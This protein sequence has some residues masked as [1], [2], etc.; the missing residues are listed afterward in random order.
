MNSNQKNTESQTKN[1]KSKIQNYIKQQ[2][3][4]SKKKDMT[5]EKILTQM[6]IDSFIGE[7]EQKFQTTTFDVIKESLW[8][9]QISKQML[10]KIINKNDKILAIISSIL[11]ILDG[12]FNIKSNKINLIYLRVPYVLIYQSFFLLQSTENFSILFEVGLHKSI[13]DSKQQFICFDIIQKITLIDIFF[14]QKGSEITDTILD[15][16]RNNFQDFYRSDLN[17]IECISL[18]LTGIN[19][20]SQN[21]LF[22][23]EKQLWPESIY[24]SQRLKFIQWIPLQFKQLMEQ[25]QNMLF[26]GQYMKKSFHEKLNIQFYYEDIGN[27]NKYKLIQFADFES[28]GQILDLLQKSQ[29]FKIKLSNQE[30]QI[31]GTKNNALVIG[32]SGTGKTT[33]IVLRIFATEMLVKVRSKLLGQK[34]IQFLQDY[35]NK[36]IQIHSIFST[37]NK[38]LVQEVEKYYHK[39]ERQAS[40]AIIKHRQTQTFNLDESFVSINESVI[41]NYEYDV[42]DFILQED[43][44]QNSQQENIS[45]LENSKSN[46]KSFQQINF[47]GFLSVEQILIFLDKQSQN[48]FFS[49][50]RINKFR[51][52]HR[53][54]IGFL[55]HNGINL[56]EWFPQSN[57]YQQT[58][59]Q[60]ST[61]QS[62]KN[63]KEIII[64]EVDFMLFYLQFWPQEAR[65]VRHNFY[66]IALPSLIWTQIYSYI[67]GSQYSYMYP[68]RYLPFQLYKERVENYLTEAQIQEIYQCFE[69]YEK[70]K[71]EQKLFDQLD[72]INSLLKNIEQNQLI[73]FPIHYSYVD[74]VQDLPQAMI[75]LFCKIT[76]QG[77]IFCGDT[78]Q[79]ILKGIGFRFSDLQTIFKTS[80]QIGSNQIEKFQVYQL[81]TNF[82]SHNSIL[83][84]ANCI[85]I[86]LELLFPNSLDHLQ[87]EIS[88]LKGP[89]PI[90]ISNNK[91]ELINDY[92]NLDCDAEEQCDVE[93]GFNQ[94]IIVK[95]QEAKEALPKQFKTARVLTT[96]QAKGLEFD[97]VII[98]NCFST[99]PIPQEQWSLL[100]CIDVDQ[101]YIDKQVFEESITKY[102]EQNNTNDWELTKDAQYVIQKKLKL[103]QRYDKTKVN[104]YSSL[105]NE[106]KMLYV[107]ITRA[108]KR[109]IIYDDEPAQRSHLERILKKYNVCDFIEE[110]SQ[111]LQLAQNRQ[112]ELRQKQLFIQKTEEQQ[113]EFQEGQQK[114]KRRI[115]NEQQKQ[116]WEQQGQL[117]FQKKLYDEAEKCF[118]ICQNQKMEYLSS[119]FNIATKGS[120]KLANYKSYKIKFQTAATL[121][122][123]KKIEQL[124]QQLRQDF[125][126]AAFKF[127]DPLINDQFQ[128]A[129]CFYSGMM[130]EDSTILFLNLKLYPQAAKSAKKL[131]QILLAIIIY[132][133]IGRLT[134][135]LKLLSN[136]YQDE[137]FKYEVL[138]LCFSR[139]LLDKDEIKQYLLKQMKEKYNIFY[140]LVE[141]SKNI[142]N[143]IINKEKFILENFSKNILAKVAVKDLFDQELNAI[144]DSQ[145]YIKDDLEEMM[146][147]QLKVFWN[148]YF[149]IIDQNMIMNNHNKEN[150]SKIFEEKQIK[151]DEILQEFAIEVLQQ[152]NQYQ[153]LIVLYPQKLSLLYKYFPSLNFKT[154][155]IKEQYYPKI[156]DNQISLLELFFLGQFEVLKETLKYQNEDQKLQFQEFFDLLLEK[157]QILEIKNQNLFLIKSYYLLGY[158]SQV[159]KK[160]KPMIFSQ[161]MEEM[162]NKQFSSRFSL[163]FQFHFSIQQNK[164]LNY[165]DMDKLLNLQNQ[166]EK[167]MI[168]LHFLYYENEKFQN[169]FIQSCNF[170]Q[171]L[172]LKRLL[173]MVNN[174]FNL[175]YEDYQN[176]ENIFSAI[177]SLNGKYVSESKFLNVFGQSMLI[178]LQIN[179]NEFYSDQDIYQKNIE[180]IK[181]IQDSVNQ[182][183]EVIFQFLFEEMIQKNSYQ[184][185][186]NYQFLLENE[187][188]IPYIIT[189]IDQLCYDINNDKIPK[190]NH[191]KCLI[192]AI[193]I[194]DS[195]IVQIPISIQDI[196][197]NPKTDYGLMSNLVSFYTYCKNIISIQSIEY[198]VRFHY[199]NNQNKY[200]HLD[201]LKHEIN[202]VIMILILFIYSDNFQQDNQQKQ[203]V[204]HL[205]YQIIENDY[206][207]ENYDEQNQW[208]NEI[209]NFLSKEIDNNKNLKEIQSNQRKIQESNQISQI[210]EKP[211]QLT[212]ESSVQENKSLDFNQSLEKTEEQQLSDQEKW[213]F[214]K[215]KELQNIHVINNINNNNEQNE[216]QS[217]LSEQNQKEALLEKEQDKQ[218]TTS[219]SQNQ[220]QTQNQN[221]QEE[222]YF[223]LF[224]QQ[225]HN[226]QFL[227]YL[228]QCQNNEISIEWDYDQ[229]KLYKLLKN[230]YL[231][232]IRFIIESNKLSFKNYIHHL[233]II[234]NENLL[235]LKLKDSFYKEILDL[236][237][238]ELQPFKQEKV[239]NQHCPNVQQQNDLKNEKQ[240]IQPQDDKQNEITKQVILQENS[241]KTETV[242]QQD[243]KEQKSPKN[244]NLQKEENLKLVQAKDEQKI[245]VKEENHKTEEDLNIVNQSIQSNR[246]IFEKFDINYQ[247]L[248]SLQ[249]QLEVRK[250]FNYYFKQLNNIKLIEGEKINCHINLDN[251]Q[252]PQY[253]PYNQK[254]NTTLNQQIN[255]LNF[256][257]VG[258]RNKMRSKMETG[259][260]K[261]AEIYKKIDKLKKVLHTCIKQFKQL[262]ISYSLFKELVFL[263]KSVSDLESELESQ[264]HTDINNKLDEIIN[265]VKQYPNKNKK[266]DQVNEESA[267]GKILAQ[268]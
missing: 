146:F 214:D 39:L 243:G 86:L 194:L 4:D 259:N 81:T 114:Y 121:D 80:K 19:A 267:F 192:Q 12:Y 33:S 66:D 131:K 22:K 96:Y 133:K 137:F 89:K 10:N 237:E 134:K 42:L 73:K 147:E 208:I 181:K 13:Q 125:Q 6:I 202:Q 70:W 245:K 100:A 224:E 87:K 23:F 264:K 90:I 116:N 195:L 248:I 45:Q 109:V 35:Q 48:P 155:E 30:K 223:F 38:F 231:I 106:L 261:L 79:S 95:N 18:P 266:K 47:P 239:F 232:L 158:Y 101:T 249:V 97:D 218:I 92:L 111:I 31:V 252:Q 3:R 17:Q 105:C 128:A 221:K 228:Y 46:Q 211:S 108:K 135:V 227:S 55:D 163:F 254:F 201:I 186:S 26:K 168:I 188:L 72:I 27:Q 159:Y 64:P 250:N 77:V 58:K 179:S 68:N 183:N 217:K 197:K 40:D 165:K 126:C 162:I 117:M 160:Y 173:L 129:N 144:L 234:L 104:E 84:L 78:A 185:D 44:C 2:Q 178:Q 161:R 213:S 143:Y 24:Q 56:D 41:T 198:W 222:F 5:I 49:D 260:M 246:E 190:L 16:Q 247:I 199:N 151:I 238:K 212:V 240:N 200:Y 130:Y 99:D 241:E 122:L 226:L 209:V 57:K 21:Y 180:F 164:E 174:L 189:I 258:F 167:F 71:E 119:A 132:Y 139:N 206:F 43:K 112:E 61:F 152:L 127:L 176:K 233:L 169:K 67:K 242:Q 230:V 193:Q 251:F 120:L 50:E 115:L 107:C 150:I 196:I 51:D 253:L 136:R 204:I 157:E 172:Y 153:I 148:Q 255:E 59:Y 98:Y 138:K 25:K 141:K 263:L 110:Y 124:E 268:F 1:Y 142:K 171:I 156:I 154:L 85:I 9:Y 14:Y 62:N 187:N 29:Q 94:V 54:K 65:K 184:N 182:S 32:R 207:I 7:D 88:N 76:E 203:K 145:I 28:A 52:K 244:L 103:N 149:E 63:I 93:F 102:Q 215:G 220:T 216:V 34:R 20:K 37:A 265:K 205:K 256:S 53:D 91:P 83:Q 118:Q 229:E 262:G 225:H 166:K 191:K 235:H 177:C 210:Q 219:Q 74:E 75:E 175:D 113:N 15:Y 123:K 8:Q 82:R 11:L 60:F 36:D 257:Y 140:Q 236:I 170:E 69:N